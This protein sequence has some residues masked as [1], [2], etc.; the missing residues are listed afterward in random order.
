[1]PE[2]QSVQPH[3]LKEYFK[4]RTEIYLDYLR[5]TLKEP[6]PDTSKILHPEYRF[7]FNHDHRY[8]NFH[9]DLKPVVRDLLEGR[10]ERKYEDIPPDIAIHDYIGHMASS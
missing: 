5:D 1:M 6:L 7:M 8:L 2:E 10:V 4:E 3:R 9:P